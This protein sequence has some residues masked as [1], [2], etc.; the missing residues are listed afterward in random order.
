MLTVRRPDAALLAG[1]TKGALVVGG[2][3]PYGNESQVAALGA[4]GATVIAKIGRAH[5]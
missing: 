5:V 4:A 1:I 3:D 2:M